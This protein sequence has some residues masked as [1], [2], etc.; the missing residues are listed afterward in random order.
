MS[1]LEPL[2]IK[3]IQEALQEELSYI[4]AR[5][6]GT[7]KSVKTPWKSWNR[8]Y[9]GGLE[10]GCI[11]AIAGMSGSGKT[12][13]LNQIESG[14]FDYNAGMDIE[15]LSF[16]YEML[17]RRLVG[18]KIVSKM[19]I[20]T[21]DLYSA[22]MD[23]DSLSDETLQFIKENMA[24]D[25]RSLN[26]SYV[27]FPGTA[28]EMARTILHFK[29][30]KKL[31]ERKAIL[32]VN[33]D[34]A[35]LTRA[36]AG[37]DERS[38]VVDVM[39]MFNEMKKRLPYSI[40]IIVSQLNRSIEDPDRKSTVA[41]K[42]S[43]HYPTK[44]DLYMSESIYQ[45]SDGVCIIHRPEILHLPFYGINKRPVKNLV[46]CHHIKNREGRPKV[47]VFYD[48]LVN[49]E[50]LDIVP[51][52]Q[53]FLFNQFTANSFRH[54]SLLMEAQMFKDGMEPVNKRI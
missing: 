51:K 37:R 21:K 10:T 11:Y 27:E 8:L 18:R 25:I 46:Y 13:C 9:M 43:L 20:S 1:T 3:S 32:L 49:S 40:Y 6:K 26:V 41:S 31:E 29:E 7:I 30:V 39:T 54:D 12:T 44:A 5:K 36:S 2:H 28:A 38:T 48:N 17:A 16:N 19:G 47:T 35:V 45:F 42:L 14:A 24:N 53:E 34:H 23:K 22:H 33:L 50:F 15:V 4:E 52:K